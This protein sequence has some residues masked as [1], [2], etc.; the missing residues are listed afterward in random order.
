MRRM[1]APTLRSL[2]RNSSASPRP[3]PPPSVAG[4]Q[5]CRRERGAREAVPHGVS[6]QCCGKMRSV[7][8]MSYPG[9]SV[10]AWARP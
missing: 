3:P 6:S 1:N 2:R 10:S 7:T 4:S 8:H 5:W 9:T